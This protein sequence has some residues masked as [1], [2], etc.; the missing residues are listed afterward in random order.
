M[1]THT[2]TPQSKVGDIYAVL[3]K[4]KSGDTLIIPASDTIDLVRRSLKRL[5]PEKNITIKTG[6]PMLKIY[7]LRNEDGEL[8]DFSPDVA[9]MVEEIIEAIKR[10]REANVR[11]ALNDLRP[12]QTPRP[13]DGEVLATSLFA[14][15]EDN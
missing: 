9:H 3:Q 8:F 14:L 6:D 10:D 15:R 13:P 5:Y 11:R 7:K 12:R 4:A 1:T 2:I